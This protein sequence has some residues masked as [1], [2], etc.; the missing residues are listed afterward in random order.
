ML[1]VKSKKASHTD[2]S[3]GVGNADL[4]TVKQLRIRLLALS[5][6]QFVAIPLI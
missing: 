4:S 5:C 3:S 1:G 6:A 2:F